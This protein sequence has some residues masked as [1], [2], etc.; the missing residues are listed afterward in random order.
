MKAFI[1][2]KIKSERLRAVLEFLYHEARWTAERIMLRFTFPSV[3]VAR[4]GR[5]EL[6]EV[7]KQG[8]RSQFGQ[9]Y[10]IARL[11][12]GRV[13]GGTFVDIGANDPEFNNNTY[14]FET[15]LH[16]D[17]IAVEPQQ[18]YALAWK[19]RRRAR[20]V[21]CC[22]GRERRKVEFLQY[23]SP[24]EWEDQLSCVADRARDED[25]HLKARTI[26]VEMRPLMDVM[27]EFG[28][29]DVDLMSIDV[30]GYE[31]EVLAGIDFDAVKPKIILIENCRRLG[32]DKDIRNVLLDA[33]YVFAMRIWTADDVFLEKTFADSL[34]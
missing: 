4:L 9:D 26:E 22:I 18:E 20:L 34:R 23:E 28:I 17:G 10:F 31:A 15:V 2:R 11:L 16:W 7:R 6:S 1:K 21:N 14:Y 33:G 13:R 8:F 27:N 29:R 5:D 12:G 3:Q 24:N 32:G 25:S 30:E 19:G